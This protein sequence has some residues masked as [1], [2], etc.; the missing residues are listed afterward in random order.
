MQM[1]TT[2]N[3]CNKVRSTKQMENIVKPPPPRHP[4]LHSNEVDRENVRQSFSANIKPA[5]FEAQGVVHYWFQKSKGGYG[6]W[7]LK[8]RSTNLENRQ[9]CFKEIIK[10]GTRSIVPITKPAKKIIHFS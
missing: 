4:F 5:R 8:Y 1:I 3:S 9:H 7:S 2:S 10:I 6:E